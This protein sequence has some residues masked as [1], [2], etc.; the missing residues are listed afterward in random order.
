MYRGSRPRK[1]WGKAAAA[2]SGEHPDPACGPTGVMATACLDKDIGRN[3]GSPDG[4]RRDSQ[5]DSR[6]GQA[7]PVRGVGEVHSTDEAG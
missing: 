2:A 7:G 5:L 3:T 1:G 4:G 6:E